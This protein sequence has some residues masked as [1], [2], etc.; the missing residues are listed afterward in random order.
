MTNERREELMSRAH[1]GVIGEPMAVKSNSKIDALTALPGIGAAT[2][3]KL[4]SAKIDSVAK[5]ASAGSQK[6]QDAGLSAAV[7]K[8]VSAAAKAAGKASGSAKKAASKAKA[9]TKSTAKKSSSAAKKT[10]LKAKTA[11]KKATVATKS[12]TNKAA[13]KTKA[14][15]KK[16]SKK[17]TEA[18][19]ATASKV[20]H[21]VKSS[22]SSDG[23]KG[24]T[25]RVPRKVTDMPW[26]NKK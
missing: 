1:H 14:A 8:K 15:A 20:K 10:A 23:R 12:A 5:V 11:A 17:A 2:A 26:F 22:K 21:T 16:V 13:S 24:S 25:L 18:K 7:A 9:V 4:V 6:L 3:K 19:K